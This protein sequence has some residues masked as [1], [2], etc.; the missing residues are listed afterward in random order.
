M[1][2][3]IGASALAFVLAFIGTLAWKLWPELTRS[4]YV[5]PAFR[6]PSPLELESIPTA[7]HFDFPL[8]NEN[9]AMAYNA[10]H[11]TENR[12]LGDDL[13]GIG[14]EN[15]DLGDPIYAIADGRVLLTRDGGAG[16]GNI[17]ILLHAYLENGKRKYVQSYYGHV[18]D[19]LVHPGEMVKRGQQI[20]TVGT[21]NGRYFA[22]LHFEMREFLTPF[23]GPGYRQDTRG[24]INPTKFIETHR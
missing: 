23:I 13:N 6:V 3:V 21:A 4:K 15:S 9:G 18:Q 19:M 20:A 16:W 1:K 2:R 17:V 7:S 8:G 22:H 14:G 12:H 10:Q 5:D 24:W 11:F